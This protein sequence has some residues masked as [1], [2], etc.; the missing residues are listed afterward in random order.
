MMNTIF[1]QT[2]WQ[3]I[4]YA[5]CFFV[6]STAF[7]E[8]TFGQVSEEDAEQVI[9]SQ[10]RA[11][12]FESL[13]VELK[14]VG[15][16]EL[17]AREA[18]DFALAALEETGKKLR[19]STWVQAG[20]FEGRVTTVQG[21]LEKI[22]SQ[23]F[24]RNKKTLKKAS[25]F[26]SEE[27]AINAYMVELLQESVTLG[28]AGTLGTNPLSDYRFLMGGSF[29]HT[30]SS[31]ATGTFTAS[32]LVRTRI[33]DSR[34]RIP[35]NNVF[36]RESWFLDLLVDA[37]F[38][39]NEPFVEI[40]S[41]SKTPTIRTA[42]S[43]LLES[44]HSSKLKMGLYLASPPIFADYGAI[45]LFGNFEISTRERSSDIFRR[46]IWGIRLENRS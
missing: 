4:R 30:D 21:E 41:V 20:K 19:S 13:K 28:R 45:G 35:E 32:L 29:V 17:S 22:I 18:M 27:E 23:Q 8:I 42:T 15:V 16:Q 33:Y 11:A 44:V 14:K 34:G 2:L 10:F 38:I 6:F 9:Y 46:V 12:I 24:I 3:S 36:E 7:S 31:T 26:S 37:Q 25:G 39:T 1:G 40:D 43:A 5:F